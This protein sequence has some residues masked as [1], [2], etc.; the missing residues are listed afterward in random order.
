MAGR[1]REERGTGTTTTSPEPTKAATKVVSQ[2]TC[3]SVDFYMDDVA[4]AFKALV[5]SLDKKNDIIP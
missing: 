2:P 1:V 3:L 5:L 4:Y